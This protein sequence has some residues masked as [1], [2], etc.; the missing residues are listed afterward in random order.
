[1]ELQ[2]MQ[3][4]IRSLISQQYYIVGVL[5]AGQCYGGSSDSTM[6]RR[7]DEVLIC[8]ESCL[9]LKRVQ[10]KNFKHSSA[11]VLGIVHGRHAVQP[12]SSHPDSLRTNS[13]AG[14][15]TRASCEEKKSPTY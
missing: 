9:R 1:M 2:H 15:V 3:C 14:K 4:N 8:S 5:H 13:G 10:S 7:V 6:P 12:G 11:T